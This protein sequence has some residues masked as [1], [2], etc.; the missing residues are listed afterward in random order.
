MS[1]ILNFIFKLIF[2]LYHVILRLGD[3]IF[4]FPVRLGRII[5]HLSNGVK[6]LG[7]P[8]EKPV[9]AILFW[10][11]ETL[12]MLLDLIGFAEAYESIAEFIKPNTRP[13]RSWEHELGK[14]IYGNSIRWHRVRIDEAAWLGPKQYQLCYVSG[15]AIN[16]WGSMDNALLIHELMHVWQYQRIGLVYIAKALRAYH[17]PENYNYGGLDALRKIK[18]EEGDIWAFNLEQ[19]GDIMADYYRISENS[20]PQWGKANLYDL[21]VY[22]YFAQQVM[23]G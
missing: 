23:N 8:L 21:P 1:C 14:R 3:V 12:L 7:T 16:S 22:A 5:R 2:K 20:A 18:A 17:S 15:F 9:N 19:Q 13:L 6:R 10:W 11:V 4:Y